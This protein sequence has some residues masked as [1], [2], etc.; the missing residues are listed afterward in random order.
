MTAHRRV[1]R[2]VAA[3]MLLAT[4]CSLGCDVAETA[5]TVASMQIVGW[6]QNNILSKWIEVRPP[7]SF[8]V[9]KVRLPLELVGT[10]QPDG[11]VRSHILTL[12]EKY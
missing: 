9:A 3:V 7:Q 1:S 2:S 10:E 5:K 12:E 4:I 6:G 8:L 11:S